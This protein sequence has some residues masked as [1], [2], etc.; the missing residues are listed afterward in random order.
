MNWDNLTVIL[1]PAVE[2]TFHYYTQA[3]CQHAP[4]VVRWLP[5]LVGTTH[6][7]TSSVAVRLTGGERHTVELPCP[8]RPV[9]VD[10]VQIRLHTRASISQDS[11]GIA[12]RRTAAILSAFILTSSFFTQASR[13][14]S[15]RKPT[16][17]SVRITVGGHRQ[18]VLSGLTGAR[19]RTTVDYNLSVRKIYEIL[20][21]KGA[22]TDLQI[23]RAH[24]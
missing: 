14:A 11:S 15:G 23:G 1:W 3:A 20:M 18:Q 2:K 21:L 12:V 16:L 13:S 8:R 9:L 17:R 4:Q 5:L 19:V 7:N 24:V 10:K 22:V 6:C